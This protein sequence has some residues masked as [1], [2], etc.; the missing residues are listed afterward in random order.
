MAGFCSCWLLGLYD[1]SFVAT[2]NWYLASGSFRCH[3]RHRNDERNFLWIWSHGPV[4]SPVSQS[5]PESNPPNR[6]SPL[7]YHPY[8]ISLFLAIL[9]SLQHHT[10]IC[11]GFSSCIIQSKR[12]GNVSPVPFPTSISHTQ[13]NTPSGPLDKGWSP[14]GRIRLCPHQIFG[15]SVCK[16]HDQWRIIIRIPIA[17]QMGCSSEPE[18]TKKK[19]TSVAS[20][21]QCQRR[22][23]LWYKCAH[24]VD[25]SSPAMSVSLQPLT[26]E[27]RMWP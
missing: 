25:W 3:L 13:T 23:L 7:H 19:T 27:V 2:K 20:N 15:R 6:D 5:S 4:P 11:N 12:K 10:H 16:S 9:L 1:D 18:A 22:C 17:A 21:S 26:P 24:S 8:L 14:K